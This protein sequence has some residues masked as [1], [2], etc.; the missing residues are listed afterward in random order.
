MHIYTL[1]L[2]FFPYILAIFCISEVVLRIGD[3]G[4]EGKFLSWLLALFL[5]F[6]SDT[7]REDFQPLAT[8][9]NEMALIRASI[10]HTVSANIKE[11]QVIQL[12]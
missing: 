3:T 1:Y 2:Y 10:A 9:D 6:K 4:L 11:I 8:S 5:L 7:G 12:E